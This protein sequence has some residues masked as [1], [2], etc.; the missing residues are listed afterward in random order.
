LDIIKGSTDFESTVPMDKSTL[1][2]LH[3]WL[4]KYHGRLGEGD[5]ER[6][7]IPGTLRFPVMAVY[8]RTMAISM[9]MLT[10]KGQHFKWSYA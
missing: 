7:R 10:W 5:M 3:L 1:Q 9:D 8:T 4:R 6:V 2:C